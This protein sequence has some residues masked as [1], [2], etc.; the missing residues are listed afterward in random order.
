MH[1]CDTSAIAAVMACVFLQQVAVHGHDARAADIDF[2]FAYHLRLLGRHEPG[3]SAM[4]NSTF[5][6][7][8]ENSV[9]PGY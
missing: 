9:G 7:W 4:D 3:S 1:R 6:N 5:T 8:H 2:G